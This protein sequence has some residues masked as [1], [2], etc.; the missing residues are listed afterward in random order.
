[1][2][3][4]AR[5]ALSRTRSRTPGAREPDTWR[6]PGGG[7]RA[8]APSRTP[9]ATERAPPSLPLGPLRHGEVPL[10][11][12]PVAVGSATQAPGAGGAPGSLC[13]LWDLQSWTSCRQPCAWP[14]SCPPQSQAGVSRPGTAGWRSTKGRGHRGPAPA[15]KPRPRPPCACT[16]TAHA[17]KPLGCFGPPASG[18]ESKR[19]RH[20]ARPVAGHG[21]AFGGELCSSVFHC[22]RR[23]QKILFLSSNA[24]SLG[25]CV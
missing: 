12:D 23:S 6:R 11:R 7:G 22:S 16:R 10:P 3:T 14:A 21:R 25:K 2:A 19:L 20:M 17:Q 18:T 24:T 4:A 1:M 15:A 8:P 5:C 13:V 9:S